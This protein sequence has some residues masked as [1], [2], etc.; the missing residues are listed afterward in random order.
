MKVIAGVAI[1]CGG[2]IVAGLAGITAGM[3]FR[4]PADHAQPQ[5]TVAQANTRP[6]SAFDAWQPTEGAPPP[7]TP[8]DGQ[9]V[10]VGADQTYAQ[11]EAGVLDSLKPAQTAQADTPAEPQPY[12]PSSQ[13]HDLS[14]VAYRAPATAAD[15][16]PTAAPASTDNDAGPNPR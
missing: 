14:A 8:D 7:Y 3:A 6:P 10:A 9:Q 1:L 11:M 16:A 2:A 15:P 5:T 4:D 13:D 12:G